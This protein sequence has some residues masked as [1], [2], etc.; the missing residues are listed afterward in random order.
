MKHLFLKSTPKQ[1]GL[2]LS[3]R[4]R[5]STESPVLPCPLQPGKQSS[6][7]TVRTARWAL[8]TAGA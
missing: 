5:L 3:S 4:N 2:V 7:Q 6:E 8:L 1:L